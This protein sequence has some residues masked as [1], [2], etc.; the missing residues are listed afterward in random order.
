[1][2]MHASVEIPGKTKSRAEQ[3]HTLLSELL[4][5]VTRMYAKTAAKMAAA[6]PA[7]ITPAPATDLSDDRWRCI[8]WRDVL[9]GA[10]ATP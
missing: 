9:S 8:E 1:M 2:I 4:F 5:L 10:P 6:S 7:R 3:D